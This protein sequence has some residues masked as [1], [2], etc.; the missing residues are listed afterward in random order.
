M[1][2]KLMPRDIP[3]RKSQLLDALSMNPYPN[4]MPTVYALRVRSAAGTEWK[5]LPEKTAVD[6]IR[7]KLNANTNVFLQSWNDR[8]RTFT[9]LLDA[10]REFEAC[11]GPLQTSTTK[12]TPSPT[13]SLALDKK[14]DTVSE[15][16]AKLESKDTA[17]MAVTPYHQ[18]RP[19]NPRDNYSR[20]PPTGAPRPVTQSHPVHHQSW[21][22]QRFQTRQPGLNSYGQPGRGPTRQLPAVQSLDIPQYQDKTHILD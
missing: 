5:T 8:I 11:A 4:E 19:P 10:L 1:L 17:I 16:L 21:T 9:H 13:I 6:S 2:Q 3:D 15:R 7:S 20:P 12:S 18:P 22:P 14:L